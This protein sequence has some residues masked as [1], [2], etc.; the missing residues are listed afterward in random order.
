MKRHKFVDN[1]DP[2]I[3]PITLTVSE[4]KKINIMEPVVGLSLN[5]ILKEG[6]K[7]YVERFDKQFGTHVEDGIYEKD[8]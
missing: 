1:N 5:Y 8:S 2:I 7:L 4:L 6:L 3:I